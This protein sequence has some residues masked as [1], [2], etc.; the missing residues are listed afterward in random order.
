MA[1]GTNTPKSD[2][3]LFILKLKSK[4]ENGVAMV[5]NKF[6]V[7]EKLD[8]K[9][10][11]RPELEA[12]VS[13]NLVKIELGEGEYQGKK[14]D[15]AKFYLEDSEAKEMYLLD[16][17]Y[18]LLSRN[19][20]NSLINLT[21]FDGVRV[22]NYKSKSKKDGKEWAAISLWQ[23]DNMVRGKYAFEVIPKPDEIKNRAGEVV[24]RD[25]AEVDG[26]YREQL[27]ELAM[28]VNLKK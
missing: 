27:K 6:S 20:F 12:A 19:L 14:Y 28:R 13:G 2:N 10:T 18:N 16:L 7:S 8:D 23:G 11:P 1:L 4:D 22:S 24:Q 15:T 26:F 3:K 21:T 25:F 5:P 17:R 9:W